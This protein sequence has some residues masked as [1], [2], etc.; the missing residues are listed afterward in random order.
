MLL[1]LVFYALLILD[2]YGATVMVHFQP[3]RISNQIT[4]WQISYNETDAPFALNRY[5]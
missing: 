1:L 2:S 5:P 3:F 4:H